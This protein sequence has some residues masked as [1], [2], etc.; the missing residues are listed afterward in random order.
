MISFEQAHEHIRG[1]S[2]AEVQDVVVRRLRGED[3]APAG[4][5]YFGE[6]AE[7]LVIRLLQSDQL[8][9]ATRRSVIAGCGEVYAEILAW[10]VPPRD[11]TM[12]QQFADT[13]TRA[14][15]VAE[16]TKRPEFSPLAGMVLTGFV[17]EPSSIPKDALRASVRAALAYVH[18]GDELQVPMWQV[19]LRT[20]DVA[21]YGFSGLLRIQPHSDRIE[22]AS[23]ELFSRQMIDDW[24][25]DAPFLL[26][27]AAR[28]RKSEGLIA[29]VLRAIRQ[30]DQ[31]VTDGRSL[32]EAVQQLLQERSWTREW[33][34]SL[35]IEVKPFEGIVSFENPR[36][37]TGL[38]GQKF[39]ITQEGQISYW[40][41][42]QQFDFYTRT[43]DYALRNK[44]N[45][46]LERVMRQYGIAASLSTRILQDTKHA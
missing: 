11:A 42:R 24:P 1:R 10:C 30:S 14:S 31:V 33:L 43:T 21:A 38:I 34:G 46:D 15:R 13:V 44:V 7:D 18:P 23:K 12:R 39:L 27:R 3:T 32:W 26:R 41:Y 36:Q 28:A 25:V 17:H 16:L 2:D 5:G 20:P 22:Q 45:Q 8:A 4:D 35:A 9:D 40:S 37:Q 19:V 6:P 29:R